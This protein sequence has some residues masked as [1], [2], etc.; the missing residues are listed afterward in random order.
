MSLVTI[1]QENYK[2]IEESHLNRWRVHNGETWA[3][4]F[5]TKE[6]AIKFAERVGG[7]FVGKCE[8]INGVIG[9]SRVIKV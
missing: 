2:D 1:E 5:N 7:V 8:V 4:G 3:H 6:Q 9:Y